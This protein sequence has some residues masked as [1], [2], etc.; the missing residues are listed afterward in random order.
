MRKQLKTLIV[1][2]FFAGA[3]ITL[4]VLIDRRILQFN[5]DK[6]LTTY[7]LI[8]T[9]YA[10]NLD[11]SLLT[12]KLLEG[13]SDE[14]SYYVNKE[15]YQKIS[16]EDQGKY[17]GIG[18]IYSF[19]NSELKV[20]EVFPDTP[21]EEAGINLGDIISKIN[22]IYLSSLKTSEEVSALLEGKEGEI[23]SLTVKTPNQEIKKVLLKRKVLN[24]PSIT[25]KEVTPEIGYLKIYEFRSTTENEFNKAA[26]TLRQK[27]INKLIIDLR[28]NLGG[29]TQSALFIDRQFINNG[30]LLREKFKSD[31]DFITRSDTKAPF[32]NIQIIILTNKETSSAAEQMATSFQDNQRAKIIGETTYGKASIGNYFELKDGSAIH[33][34]IGFWLRPNGESINGKGVQPDITIPDERTKE[35]DKLLDKAIDI[36]KQQ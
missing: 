11:E 12:S 22:N 33:L 29:K 32:E 10:G 2:L 20:I 27:N 30:I 4:G 13:L 24:I 23:L 21:A 25:F 26:E 7:S 17:I 5:Q 16:S 19:R 15:T 34:T 6:P 28:N 36:I 35:S 18:F 8:K 14:Y 1:I 3:F 9:Q 31:K